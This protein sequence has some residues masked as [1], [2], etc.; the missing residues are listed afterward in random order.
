MSHVLGL[1]GG[2]FD[3]VHCG[4]LALATAALD[5]KAIDRVRW[6][7]G[8][9][10]PHRAGPQARAEDRLEM[11]KLM[12]ADHPAFELD[13]GEVLAAARG[14]PS[15]T[16]LTLERLRRALGPEQP[17]ALILGA[18]AFLGLPTWHRWQE[19]LP[20]T[21]LL[22]TTRAGAMLDREQMPAAL[23]P[24]WAKQQS[25]D[26]ATLATVPGG[27]IYPFPMPSIDISATE[28]RRRLPDPGAELDGLLS[29]AVLRYIRHH[30]L[31]C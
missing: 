18:D 8:G 29:P 14:E 23:R 3:P 5:S 16:I 19:I 1:L 28:L 24:V 11:V 20:L 4:H 25:K 27:L 2:T 31:Y 13:D 9:Q 22:I 17:L 15:Y 30:Q 26:P 7:P 21:H 10:P 6:I 12:I